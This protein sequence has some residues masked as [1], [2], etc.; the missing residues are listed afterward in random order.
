MKNFWKSL[1]QRD[2]RT[3]AMVHH[4]QEERY[5]AGIGTRY[6]SER[7]AQVWSNLGKRPAKDMRM[8]YQ[9]ALAPHP[10]PHML[11]AHPQPITYNG[12]G[13]RAAVK[14]FY[15]NLED[16]HAR[17]RATLARERHVDEALLHN[18]RKRVERE[19]V[20]DSAQ[21]ANFWQ[22]QV[23]QD[24]AEGE[25]EHEEAYDAANNAKQQ[26]E[27]SNGWFG[28]DSQNTWDI[29]LGRLDLKAKQ[30]ANS[31]Q[32]AQQPYHP[33]RATVGVP[34]RQHASAF[35]TPHFDAN[36]DPIAV[37][38]HSSRP[39]AD[40]LARLGVKISNTLNDVG[41]VPHPDAGKAAVERAAAGSPLTSVAQ[42]LMTGFG[43][44]EAAAR[45]Q[46]TREVGPGGYTGRQQRS[47]ERSFYDG[48][49]E[50][51]RTQHALASQRD[52]RGKGAEVEPTSAVEKAADVSDWRDKQ[53][54][55]KFFDAISQ[56]D[57]A[58][59]R[60]VRAR[61]A[62]RGQR[63]LQYLEQRAKG[64]KQSHLFREKPAESDEQ[65]VAGSLKF[66]SD[67]LGLGSKRRV[68]PR[69]LATSQPVA[70]NA[71]EEEDESTKQKM[72]GIPEEEKVANAIT[73]HH[74]EIA[75]SPVAERAQ[76]VMAEGKA[77]TDKNWDHS[78]LWDWITNIMP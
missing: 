50:A 49:K 61:R 20:V 18:L 30:G 76:A 6:Q 73:D 5:H 56:H 29:D 14:H 78:S 71:V 48:L 38:S 65:R 1:D 54:V 34:A 2:A 24:L 4:L 23:H 39:E 26:K 47:E 52:R 67:S 16:N 37:P 11:H 28:K 33:P 17:N 7:A 57:A 53:R 19:N 51:D 63:G 44:G 41:Y 42:T 43:S 66:A 32:L 3:R 15:N 13:S 31:E 9:S 27:H 60:H 10:H 64:V 77:K 62:E 40:K 58:R 12:R 68:A 8:A 72:A 59:A 70:R 45:T 74:A 75:R 36:G 25:K 21:V 35:G 69:Q 55:D 46:T 22:K